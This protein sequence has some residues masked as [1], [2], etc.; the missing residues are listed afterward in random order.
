M[1]AYVILSLDGLDDDLL[2]ATVTFCTHDLNTRPYTPHMESVQ[3]AAVAEVTLS[4]YGKW[5]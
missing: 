3:D 4:D 5:R 1:L 2:T